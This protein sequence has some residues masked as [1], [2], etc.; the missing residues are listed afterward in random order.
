MLAL[1]SGGFKLWQDPRLCLWKKDDRNRKAPLEPDQ[2]PAD[3]DL[4]NGHAEGRREF[5]PTSQ[6]LRRKDLHHT[7][8]ITQ[9]PTEALSSKAPS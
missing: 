1:A 3:D 8:R 9:M 6:A 5:Y 2:A 4:W 7:N